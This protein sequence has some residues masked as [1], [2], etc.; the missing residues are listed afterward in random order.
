[1]GTGDRTGRRFGDRGE[2]W[3]IAQGVLFLAAAVAPKRGMW[4]DGARRMGKVVGVPVALA[5]VGLTAAGF[6]ALGEN[7]TP[8]PHPKEDGR[9]VQDGVYGVVRHP[10]YGGLILGTVG[11]GLL[12]GN[13]ARTLLGLAMT[14]FFDAKARREEAW[15]VEKFS[16]YPAYRRTVKKLIPF[17]Y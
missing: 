7:L 2:A 12:T 5:G 16:A 11:A 13:T 4:P 6:R 1:M 8:L 14:L 15:L 3:V 10:I 17:V 9:L